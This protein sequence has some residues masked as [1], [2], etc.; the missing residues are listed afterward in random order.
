MS[1][2]LTSL[3][4]S[5]SASSSS[6]SSSSSSPSAS[7]SSSSQYAIQIQSALDELTNIELQ[8]QNDIQVI[9]N[10]TTRVR[11][12][13]ELRDNIK[14]RIK[15]VHNRILA[16][17]NEA[18]NLHV[19]DTDTL[20]RLSKHSIIVDDMYSLLRRAI[21]IASANLER[22]GENN[23]LL[24]LGDVSSLHQRR[25]LQEDRSADGRSQEFTRALQRTH[26]SLTRELQRS[27]DALEVLDE[28]TKT[29]E[30][31]RDEYSE[32]GSAIISSRRMANVII[33]RER[34]DIFLFYAA[35]LFF[36]LVV[37]YIFQKRLAG[38]FPFSFLPSFSSFFSLLWSLV[39]G[40]WHML[41]VLFSFLTYGLFGTS[42]THSA[43]SALAP[44]TT[45][46]APPSSSSPLPSPSPATVPRP[47]P[48][49][50]EEA[51]HEAYRQEANRALNYRPP[52]PEL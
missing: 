35:L 21:L 2:S 6:S 46:F 50:T 31:T 22:Q 18:A 36:F 23:R 34:T 33:G 14:D 45:P 42:L 44:S 51:F 16:L 28:S 47:S 37:L 49:T 7:A 39:T 29:L 1:E 9:R 26:H 25:A 17:Q 43:N 8:I 13:D 40:F 5:S 20:S 12:V 3:S 15:L 19:N 41:T 24:L 11:G 27:T 10:A 52:K 32:Y 4:S 48:I 30:D 38:M